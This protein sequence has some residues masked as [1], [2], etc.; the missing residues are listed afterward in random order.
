MRDANMEPFEALS[1][2]GEIAIAITGF[3][4][5]VLVFGGRGGEGWSEVDRVRFR[6]LFTGSLIPLGLIA[7][8]SVLDSSQLEQT[9]VWRICSSIYFVCASATAFLNVRAA[10]RAESGDARLRM[11][12]FAHIW[13]GG[14]IALAVAVLVLALQ[15]ANV[16]ALHT[17]WPVLVAVW[18]GIALGLFSFVGLVFPPQDS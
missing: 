12:R 1:L 14:A 2:C 3:S 17:F 11:P 15:L 16:V 7:V 4:G 9:N 13:R 18:W 8:A 10:A 5:V 6:M